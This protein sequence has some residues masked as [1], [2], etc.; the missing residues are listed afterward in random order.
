MIGTKKIDVRL[1]IEEFGIVPSIRPAVRSSTPDDARF[2]AETLNSSGIPIAEIHMSI[3]GAIQVISHLA[4]DFPEMIVGADLLDVEMAR[5][6]LDA[7]AKFLTCPG[8]LPDIVEFAIQRDV[9]V[10]PAAMTP[11]E[12][13][14]AWKAGADFVKV[15]PCGQVGGAGYIKALHMTFP[16]VP[17]IASGGVNQQTAGNFI[18]AGATALAIGPELIPEEALRWQKEDQICELARRFLTMVKT[19]RAQRMGQF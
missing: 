6:C 8:L 3:P 13:L 9:V 7:G 14:Q 12:T 19:G 1:R 17:L 5:R 2:A 15:F 4:K 10:I 18:L 16:Q 11:T